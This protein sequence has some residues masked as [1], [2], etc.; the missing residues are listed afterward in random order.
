LS[1][2]IAGIPAALQASRRTAKA[3]DDNRQ[4]RARGKVQEMQA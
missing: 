3:F 2:F 4:N 1:G